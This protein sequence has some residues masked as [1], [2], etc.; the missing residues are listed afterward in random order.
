MTARRERFACLVAAGLFGAALCLLHQTHNTTLSQNPA[1]AGQKTAVQPAKGKMWV[2]V[3]TY[4]RNTKSKGIYRLDFDPETGKLTA[5]VVA[6][7]TVDPSFLA[8]HP[9]GKYLYACNETEQFDGKK[10][11]G[12]L[13][14]FALDAKTGKLTLLNQK[15]S[16][17][18]AP[19]HLVC[20]NAGK[21][22]LAANYTGGSAIV[23]EILDDGKLG[24]RTGFVQHKGSGPDKGRQE[25]PH[26]HSINLDKGNH[27]AF[28]ADLGLDK[29]MIYKFDQAKGS[30]TPNDPPFTETPAGGGP[31]HF[32]F[33]PSGKYAYTCNE[34]GMSVT[35]MNYD[36]NKGILKPFQTITTLPK[37]AGGKG[38]ST[39]EVQ[40]H[41]SGKFVYVS[42]RGHNS[43]AIF[44]VDAETGKLSVVGH[45]GKEIKT[46]RNFGIDPTGKF[47]IVANQD[48]N[49]LV[50][51]SID[52]KTGEL[53]PTETKI[54]VPRPVCVKFYAA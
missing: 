25:N 2:Y 42:N 22:V 9:S 18:A 32:A 21:H 43:I 46:P 26:A 6:G 28:V 23:Y 14:A 15:T 33:H 51:F 17:G 54:E 39:A 49:S 29:I 24:E 45:Q 1:A 38:N 35:A 11:S 5:P 20:D 50:V 10:N 7:E 19:C 13:S 40:V 12:G 41:P 30:L 44:A 37:G 16:D 52:Q 47:M 8:L 31:R 36:A 3:G 27:F 34:M 53:H 4:T 48:G